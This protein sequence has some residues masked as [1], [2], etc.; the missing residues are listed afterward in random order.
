GAAWRT[1]EEWVGNGSNDPDFSRHMGFL[2]DAAAIGPD[3]RLRFDYPQTSSGAG[4]DQFHVDDVTVGCST[5]DSDGD[6][7]PDSHDCD[8]ADGWHWADCGLC[9]DVDGDG[10]G[11]GC[12]L[13]G[14][15]AD[16]DA[17]TFPGAPDTLGDG[18][19]TDCSG[20]D[21]QALFEDFESGSLGNWRWRPAGDHVWVGS[22]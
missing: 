7:Q 1:L 13:G 6:G 5:P 9:V 17:T 10:F 3:F 15:C 21:G 18:V 16:G 4:L 22:A 14:D 2:S 19:D 12:D 8:P 11:L 20:M